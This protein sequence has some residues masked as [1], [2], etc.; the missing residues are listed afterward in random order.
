MFFYLLR[1]Y[2]KKMSKDN[3]N[4]EMNNNNSKGLTEKFTQDSFYSFLWLFSFRLTSIIGSI[5][6]AFYLSKEFYGI[7]SIINLWGFFL[8][9]ICTFGLPDILTKIITENRLKNP[10]KNRNFILSTNFIILFIITIVMIISIFTS[11][12]FAIGIYN[13][14][15][16]EILLYLILVKVVFSTIFTINQNVLRGFREYKI[17]ATFLIMGYAIKIPLLIISLIFFGLYGIF[18]T[19]I[20]V[21]F[22]IFL[23]ITLKTRTVTSQL[24]KS[25]FKFEFSE[26][27]TLLKQ[28]F[29]LFFVTLMN[30][31]L[32]WLS[33]TIFSIYTSFNDVS[34][35]QISLNVM[36]IILLISFSL[37]MALLPEITEKKQSDIKDF[38]LTSEKLIK[39]NALLTILAIFFVLFFFPI[40][41]KIFYPNY[42]SLVT[43]QSAIILSPYIFFY[44]FF[45]ISNQILI[46]KEKTWEIFM[47]NSFYFIIFIPIL[48][49]FLILFQNIGLPFT[50]FVM[51]VIFFPI[52]LFFLSKNEIKATKSLIIL[53]IMSI[54][55]FI[56]LNYFLSSFIFN[57]FL[58][59]AIYASIIFGIVLII[60]IVVIKRDENCAAYV[61]NMIKFFGGIKNRE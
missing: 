8:A 38:Q 23:L 13:T 16:I 4:D 42:D 47:I 14:S 12:I 43:F 7:Y 20:I 57:Q 25:A 36:N 49:L 5:I 15:I 56:V 45:L 22:V 24:E 51:G 35:F 18:Y 53:G 32:N 17:I 54:V 11:R 37:N 60:I 10:K 50:F 39:L 29:P 55:T 6:I 30:L 59:W 21:N 46:V 1:S 31:L 58:I 61:Q 41:I 33:L 26:I 28:S 2:I 44:S 9:A 3:F 19:E 48:F 40:I 27:K 34:Y 52:Y